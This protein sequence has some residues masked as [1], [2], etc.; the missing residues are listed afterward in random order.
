MSNLK[1]ELLIYSSFL[2]S[3]LL[4]PS[5]FCSV[6]P[7]EACETVG[8]EACAADMYPEVKLEP[9]ANKPKVASEPIEREYMDYT[10]PRT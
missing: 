6:F 1:E 8:G 3:N 2:L 5:I 7:A 4:I 10:D 9:E